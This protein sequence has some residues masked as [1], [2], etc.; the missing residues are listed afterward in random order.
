MVSPSQTQNWN[1]KYKVQKEESSSPAV[2][3][4]I[5]N[6]CEETKYKI[7]SFDCFISCYFLT[8]KK[9]KKRKL[10][11]K[12]EQ[13]TN[14]ERNFRNKLKCKHKFICSSSPICSPCLHLKS[15]PNFGKW[16]VTW[17]YH[18]IH[19]ENNSVLKFSFSRSEI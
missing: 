12:S 16:G 7:S 6:S 14:W 19:F 11:E 17:Y 1:M 13:Q 3:D 2:A 10:C 18:Y 5:R 9:L 8:G 15:L 4:R